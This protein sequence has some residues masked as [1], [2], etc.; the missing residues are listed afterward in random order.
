MTAEAEVRS[1][2][3]EPSWPEGPDRQYF[4]YV[5]IEWPAPRRSDGI[6]TLPSAWGCSILDAQTGKPLVTVE[7]ITVQRVTAEAGGFVV[8]DLV[9]CADPDGNPVLFPGEDGRCPAYPDDQ[10]RIRTGVFPFIVAE[11]RVR[12]S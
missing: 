8:A 10:G 5:I 2:E 3:D 1:D 9:A 6:P 7:K 11:M 12:E 4:G